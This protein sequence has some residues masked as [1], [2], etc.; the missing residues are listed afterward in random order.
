MSELVQ[1]NCIVV[2]TSRVMFIDSKAEE[3]VDRHH[4]TRSIA[5]P[6]NKITGDQHHYV[7]LKFTMHDYYVSN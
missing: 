5:R 6:H 1:K 3:K 7:S 2:F 4:Q